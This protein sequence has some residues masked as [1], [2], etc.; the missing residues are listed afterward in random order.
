M[1]LSSGASITNTWNASA[2]GTSGAV[3]FTNVVV[4]RQVAAGA[5][6]QFGFQGTGNGQGMSPTCTAL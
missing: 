6:T 5:S 4:Q 2:S 1:T 3:Q